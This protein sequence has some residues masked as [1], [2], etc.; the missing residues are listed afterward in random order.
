[1]GF[2]DRFQPRFSKKYCDLNTIIGEALGQYKA[3]VE[4]GA[5]PAPAHTF[6][7]K[8]EELAKIQ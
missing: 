2:F 6:T 4:S 7:I 8:D 3:E 1:V 5:F